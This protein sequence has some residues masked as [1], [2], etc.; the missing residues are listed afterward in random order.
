MIVSFLATILVSILFSELVV[1]LAHF[2][3]AEALVAFAPG[4]VE[5]MSILALALQLD[6]VFVAAHHIVR[7]VS[8]GLALPVLIRI[9][10]EWFGLDKA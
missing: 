4:G 9:R 2:P 3:Q 7:F 1:W 8:I 5:A 10:P 6:S